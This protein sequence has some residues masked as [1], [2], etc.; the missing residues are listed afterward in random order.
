ML[1]LHCKISSDVVDLNEL[2][3]E[4]WWIPN[5]NMIRPHKDI[6]DSK[7]EFSRNVLEKWASFRDFIL[8]THFRYRVNKYN[9]LLIADDRDKKEE[10]NFRA[11]LFPYNLPVGVNHYV[12][13]NSKY[14]YFT[15]FDEVKI[16]GIIK[17]CL[18]NMLDSDSFDF[19]WYLNPKPSIPE[20]W[21]CQVFWI[22]T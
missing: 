3:K 7:R 16:N 13:W 1:L 11:A 22:R 14:N 6:L 9:N 2:H 10:W 5:E 18:S 19:A 21:H 15:G 12:L 17:E 8:D 4:R 20:L